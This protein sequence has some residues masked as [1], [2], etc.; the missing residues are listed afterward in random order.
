MKCPL[1][2][3]EKYIKLQSYEGSDLSKNW[4]KQFGF[5]AFDK[6]QNN[7]LEKLMCVDCTLIFFYP[8]YYGD[9]KFYSNLSQY[10][11]YYESDKWE[12]SIAID[13][14]KKYRP[15]SLLEIGCGSGE[16]L[17]K[18][19]PAIDYVMGIDIN[20]SALRAARIKGLHVSS[21]AIE[22]LENSFDMIVLFEVLEH[23][24][25]PGNV[26]KAIYKKLNPGG[27]LIVAVPNPESY[28]KDMGTVLLDMP[29]H[30]NTCW[31]KSTFQ[32]VAKYIQLDM[33]DYKMEPL[34]YVHYLG[35]LLMINQI[36]T[37]NQFMIKLK[38][39]LCKFI[40]PISYAT[41]SKEIIGQTHL[42]VFKK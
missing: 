9:S 23:L 29:P 6:F 24:A 39:L 11:W 28:L 41:L 40:A 13:L 16:F 17:S 34:R 26:L 4:L 18:V 30:H 38:N 7:T 31:S 12:F 37:K 5:D 25:E 42:A 20:Q 14:I 32:F 1:C 27:L 21:C 36:D 19:S 10:D 3:S 2:G 8:G 15:T 22:E 33:L 35:Y